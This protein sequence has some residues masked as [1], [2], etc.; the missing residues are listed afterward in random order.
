MSNSLLLYNGV[1]KSE[2]SEKVENALKKV[3]LE[4]RKDDKPSTFFWWY[5]RRLNIACAIAH[6]PKLIYF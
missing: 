1:K 5:E 6:S 2:I 3:G 4:D